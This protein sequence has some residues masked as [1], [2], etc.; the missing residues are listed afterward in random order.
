[1]V[2]VVQVQERICER[3]AESPL[4][5]PKCSSEFRILHRTVEQLLTI[6]VA[7]LLT[8][9]FFLQECMFVWRVDWQLEVSKFSS[10]DRILRQ[11][12]GKC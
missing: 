9:K 4:E 5:V 1:M 8:S 3:S 12:V 6:L 2:P 7:T 10:Q 11:A